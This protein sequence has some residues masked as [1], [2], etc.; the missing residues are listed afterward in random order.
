MTRGKTKRKPRKSQCAATLL[1]PR[2]KLMIL[3]LKLADP[4]CARTKA[5]SLVLRRLI[6]VIEGGAIEEFGLYMGNF[7]YYLMVRELVEAA[8]AD[9]S[10]TNEELIVWP[11]E[12]KTW[13]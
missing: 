13:N 1:V 12:I 9:E 8:I 5:L 10:A 4:P 2:L 7:P 3:T 6:D 11:T